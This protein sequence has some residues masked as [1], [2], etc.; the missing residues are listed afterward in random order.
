MAQYRPN[1]VSD[2][3]KRRPPTRVRLP[4]WAI[5][6]LSILLTALLA[7][8]GIRLFHWMVILSSN[9][10][11]SSLQAPGI[12]EG[13]AVQPGVANLPGNP[14]PTPAITATPGPS[15]FSVDAFQAWTGRDRVTVLLLGIDLRCEESG[16]TRTDSMMLVTLD[17]VG[18]SIAA[19]S[20]PRDL[21]VEIPYYGLDRVNT[22]YYVGEA[23]EY[24]GGG[25]MLAKATVENFLGIKINYYLAID[26]D[27][28]I[29]IVDA[30]GGIDL[31]VPEAINDPTYPDRCYG[32]EGFSIE[33]GQQ[34]LDGQTALKY[35]R[36]RATLEGDVARAGRQQAVL[37]A[38]RD[39]VSRLNM[40][41]KLISQF[42]QLWQ[43]VQTNVRT[44]LSEVEIIQLALLAKDIPGDKIR[45]EVIDYRFVYNETTPD[46]RQ[47]LVPNRVAIRGLRDELFT[48][49]AAP[50]PDITNLPQ[51][52]QREGARVMIENGTPTFGL[53]AATQTYLAAHAVTVTGVGNADSAEYPTTQIIDFG[54]H[55]N[56][57]L[58][59]TQ[60]MG[61]PPLNATTSDLPAADYDV[62]IILGA[63]WQ[64]PQDSGG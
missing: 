57:V 14:F 47:V 63:D 62:L 24:P 33:A 15:L 1:L 16:P 19:L 34:T 36:T 32:Y 18:K 59:L 52:A 58:Y 53:A 51:L 2:E 35:A 10:G 29:E 48:A 46:G 45:S 55:P 11:V 42:P 27:G 61:L 13:G 60:L 9:I 3:A 56:T 25:P 49:I 21:W 41:P 54:Q 50:P 8:G 23:N 26:F 37:L 28:F 6:G 31:N 17:P 40:L 44:N 4:L 20:L 12:G 64:I 7:L 5:V 38:V 30:I 39:K 22:A 43:M